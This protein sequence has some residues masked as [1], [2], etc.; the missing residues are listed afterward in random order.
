M[1]VTEQDGRYKRET[2]YQLMPEAPKRT[3][4][5]RLVP[6]RAASNVLFEAVQQKMPYGTR[7]R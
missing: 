3:R 1:R 5:V 6:P 2:D 7:E 4:F